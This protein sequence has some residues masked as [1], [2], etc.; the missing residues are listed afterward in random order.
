MKLEYSVLWDSY[1]TQEVVDE[2]VCYYVDPEILI[3]A[4]ET[5]SSL[6]FIMSL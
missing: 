1:L 6:L 3:L 4:L 5:S 2:M